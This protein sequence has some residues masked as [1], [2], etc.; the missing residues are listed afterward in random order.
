MIAVAVSS[1][2]LYAAGVT[3]NY[4]AALWICALLDGRNGGIPDA[5]EQWHNDRKSQSEPTFKNGER[6]SANCFVCLV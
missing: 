3:T 1:C 2:N 5:S 6:A 4:Y